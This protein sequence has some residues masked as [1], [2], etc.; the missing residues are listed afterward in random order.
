MHFFSYPKRCENTCTV[1]SCGLKGF[2]GG[3]VA[4]NSFI[5]TTSPQCHQPGKPHPLGQLPQQKARTQKSAKTRP[6][7][8][9]SLTRSFSHTHIHF[10]YTHTQS[11]LKHKWLK[12]QK[13]EVQMNHSSHIVSYA[14]ASLATSFSPFSISISSS[15]LSLLS[16]FTLSASFC[17]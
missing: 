1:Q 11:H 3:V 14:F 4:H 2:G 6:K 5:K 12:L 10:I 15:P 9:L 17:S 16:V 8:V 13:S 7:S